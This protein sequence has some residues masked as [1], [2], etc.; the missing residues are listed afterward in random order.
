M[1]NSIKQTATC[2]IVLS[3]LWLVDC[4]VMGCF[5]TW[6]WW[7]DVYYVQSA[8]LTCP[9]L[10][11]RPRQFICTIANI[12]PCVNHY[13]AAPVT[14]ATSP[15]WRCVSVSNV[16]CFYTVLS[17]TLVH[18][19]LPINEF[20]ILMRSKYKVFSGKHWRLKHTKTSCIC[21]WVPYVFTQVT[22]A[23]IYVRV[24]HSADD[25][26]EKRRIL[27]SMRGTVEKVR[28]RYSKLKPL[29]LSC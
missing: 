14:A 11:Y 22:C 3:C 1:K 5:F 29:S 27:V 19:L 6:R 15:T 23:S 4:L 17:M 18:L 24:L 28:A 12:L 25:A 8:D 21:L 2:K 10:Q 7:Q 26:G 16:Y 9:V 20:C 13:P